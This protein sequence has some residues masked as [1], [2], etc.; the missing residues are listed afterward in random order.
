[1]KKTDGHPPCKRRRVMPRAV[2]SDVS[3]G[4]TAAA[5]TQL[6][7]HV[8]GSVADDGTPANPITLVDSSDDSNGGANISTVINNE[9]VSISY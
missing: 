7:S 5:L 8:A 6:P 1:M 9:I 2:S 4:G 3:S